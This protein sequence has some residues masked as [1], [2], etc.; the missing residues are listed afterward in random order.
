MSLNALST[1]LLQVTLFKLF[2]ATGA[3][4]V[5]RGGLLTVVLTEGPISRRASS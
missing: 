2:L 4:S 1:D 3:G 5:R